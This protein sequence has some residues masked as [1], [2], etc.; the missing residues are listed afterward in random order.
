MFKL[1]HL[2]EEEA[3]TLTNLISKVIHMD[4]FK[5]LYPYLL[6][7]EVKKEEINLENIKLK[8]EKAK[9]LI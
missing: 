9:T 5:T 6:K 7:E 8:L 3:K 2:T 1:I 4:A